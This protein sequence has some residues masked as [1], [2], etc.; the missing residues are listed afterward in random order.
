[1]RSFNESVSWEPRS[2]LRDLGLN[3]IDR[4]TRA[5]HY[6]VFCEHIDILDGPEVKKRLLAAVLDKVGRVVRSNDVREGV[7][8][9]GQITLEESAILITVQLVGIRI[10]S[11]DERV[12]VSV[13]GGPGRADVDSWQ[14][15]IV[16][17][18][19]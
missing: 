17:L 15:A 16:G 3:L 6:S 1:M 18:R 7:G 11:L 10:L 14:V 8:S 12:P 2:Q 13:I 5:R 9:R 19:N 4:L